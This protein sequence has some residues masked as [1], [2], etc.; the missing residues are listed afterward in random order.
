MLKGG[1]IYES[2]FPEVLSRRRIIRKRFSLD[3]QIEKRY[4]EERIVG[5]YL[6]IVQ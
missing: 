6:A 2:I 5:T 3:D 1:L 4:F